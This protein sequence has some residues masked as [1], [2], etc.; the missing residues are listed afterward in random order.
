MSDHRQGWGVI[1]RQRFGAG[2]WNA[3]TER[4][5]NICDFSIIRGDNDLVKL[6]TG[7][8]RLDRISDDRLSGEQ[9]DILAGDSLTAP[10]GRDDRDVHDATFS[11]MRQT[12]SITIRTS[13]SVIDPYRGKLNARR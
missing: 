1:A 7:N 5:G 10:A 4:L 11:H 8:R 2:K 6:T 12:A 9:A 3:R 13:E